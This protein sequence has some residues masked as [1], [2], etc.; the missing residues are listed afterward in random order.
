[1]TG[2]VPA[3]PGSALETQESRGLGL[4]AFRAHEGLVI[5]GGLAA[6]YDDLEEPLIWSGP[7]GLSGG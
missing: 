2:T 6:Y 3:L 1:M 5:A 4:V 7:I